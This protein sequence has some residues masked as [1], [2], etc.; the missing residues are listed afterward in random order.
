M[1]KDKQKQFEER[2]LNFSL[3]VLRLVKSLPK[4]E[5]NRIYDK[6]IIRSS[7]SVGAN[8]SEAVFAHTKQDFI[9][10]LNISRKEASETIYWLKLLKYVNMQYADKIN[11][12]I[13]ENEQ[14]LR[15][16]I[17]SVKTR[18]ENLQND[19]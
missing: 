11:K 1:N 14:I 10:S 9:H 3:E 18:K 2:L 19:K 15:I 7:S 6:Q 5:E 4:T 13:D 8:Y 12:I 17:S 16:F